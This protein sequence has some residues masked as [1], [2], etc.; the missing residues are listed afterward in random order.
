MLPGA[1]RFAR[2]SARI[3]C[4]RSQARSS[5]GPR[6]GRNDTLIPGLGRPAR[7]AAWF[8][9]AICSAVCASGSPHRANTSACLPPTR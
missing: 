4:A 5:V 6:T 3:R 8:T 1:A 7:S 2:V 9:A